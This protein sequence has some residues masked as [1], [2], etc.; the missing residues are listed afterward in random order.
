[1]QR[2]LLVKTVNVGVTTRVGAIDSVSVALRA[3][4]PEVEVVMMEKVSE[5]WFSLLACFHINDM[6]YHLQ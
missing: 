5:L 2:A 4:D 3:V 1:M 6:F